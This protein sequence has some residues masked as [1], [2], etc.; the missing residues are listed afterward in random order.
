MPLERIEDL[1]QL[2]LSAMAQHLVAYHKSLT[3]AFRSLE[4]LSPKVFLPIV[5][6]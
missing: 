2:F 6:N 4:H 3:L 5:H 1:D